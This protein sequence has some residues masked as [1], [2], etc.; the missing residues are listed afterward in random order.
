M[1]TARK[2]MIA[3]PT[4]L[5]AI[6][7][8]LFGLVY[9]KARYATAEQVFKAD[10]LLTHTDEA[11]QMA[12]AGKAA[13]IRGGKLTYKRLDGTT[14]QE[15]HT[16]LYIG[17]NVDRTNAAAEKEYNVFYSYKP[18]RSFVETVKSLEIKK[19]HASLII[20]IPTN[21]LTYAGSL[22]RHSHA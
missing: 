18:H 7:M 21:L 12:T 2:I 5:V 20:S 8:I 4:G 22:T 17:R 1:T 19:W 10:C 6:I 16:W 3:I 14:G 15:R 9:C 11:A 13:E